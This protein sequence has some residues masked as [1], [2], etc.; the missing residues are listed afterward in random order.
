MKHTD[1]IQFKQRGEKIT[2]LT[3]YDASFAKMIE[4]SGVD[5]ILVGD[6][7]GMVVQGEKSTRTVSVSDM[8]Y[9]TKA[10]ASVCDNCLIIADMPHHSYDDSSTAL[11]N[12]KSLISAGAHMIKL[13]GGAERKSVIE[14]LIA[15]NIPVFSHLGLQPQQVKDAS[16]YKIQG[17]DPS[18]AKAIIEDA[19]LLESLGVSALV[20][21]CVPSPLAKLITER[22]SIPTIGIGAGKDC[23]GQV[24]VCFDMLGIT[25]GR[26]PRFVRNFAHGSVDIPGAI[27]GFVAAVK[28]HTF[29]VERESY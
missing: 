21:E 6:S 27:R 29:P 20:L 3:A 18:S 25:Q 1:L 17:K 26:L 8:V 24:L 15:N 12:A 10:V 13:E 16:D 23:D 14:A 5:S 9:H 19:I 4:N 7:L 11:I 28:G 22:L 2:C